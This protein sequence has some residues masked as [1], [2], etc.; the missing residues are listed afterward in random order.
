LENG[1]LFYLFFVVKSTVQYRLNVV[2][3]F[4]LHYSSIAL[5]SGLVT[6][7]YSF[8]RSRPTVMRFFNKH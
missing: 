5:S 3:S 6:F 4:N 7:W 2:V 1:Y 8:N